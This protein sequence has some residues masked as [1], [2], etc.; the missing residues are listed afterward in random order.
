MKKTP[1]STVLAITDKGQ[2]TFYAVRAIESQIGG[3][4]FQLTK[5]DLWTRQTE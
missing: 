5:A 2:T 3:R 4:G 1:N